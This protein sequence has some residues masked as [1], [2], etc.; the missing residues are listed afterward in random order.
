MAGEPGEVNHIPLSSAQFKVGVSEIALT[1]VSLKFKVSSM[2]RVVIVEDDRLTARTLQH[3]CAEAF[4]S[5]LGT[6]KHFD[7]LTPAL[8]H[9]RENP[10]DL[11]VL[12]INLKG[13]SGYE[14][15]KFPE[16]ESFYTIVTSSDTQNAVSA[17]DYGVLDFVAKPFTRERFI[18]AIERMKRASQANSIHRNSISLKKDGMLEMIRYRDILYLESVGNFTDI[19]LKNGKTER[20][21]RT[22]EAILAELNSDFFRSHRSFIINLSEVSRILHCKNNTYRVLLGDSKEVALSRSRCNLLKKML[23]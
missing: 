7:S 1:D 5:D 23:G 17:F 12:D 20:I 9:I 15:L 2:V 8:F 13:E 21:R 14:I 6:I 16:K 19:H 22:M 4:G 11:L 3:F 10:I 18:S